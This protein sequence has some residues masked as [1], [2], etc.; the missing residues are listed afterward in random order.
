MNTIR[1]EIFEA[2]ILDIKKLENDLKSEVITAEYCEKIWN[3]HTDM[4]SH[5]MNGNDSLYTIIFNTLKY[6]DYIIN[7]TMA[8]R[9]NTL[10]NIIEDEVQS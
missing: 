7:Y 4:L 5:Y 3:M 6:S 10:N 2:Y 9:I 8:K 1:K